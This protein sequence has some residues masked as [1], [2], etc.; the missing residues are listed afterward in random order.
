MNL[1]KEKPLREGKTE[2][3]RR[4]KKKSPKKEKGATSTNGLVG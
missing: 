4:E 2:S 1:E 3:I